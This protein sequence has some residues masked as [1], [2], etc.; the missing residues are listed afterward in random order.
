MI[1]KDKLRLKLLKIKKI[2]LSRMFEKIQKKID[3]LYEEIKKDKHQKE[4]SIKRR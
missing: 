4:K 2:G 1:A 3:E